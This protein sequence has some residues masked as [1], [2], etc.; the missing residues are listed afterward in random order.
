MKM[1][2]VYLLF[3]SLLMPFL[4]ISQ[5]GL[6]AHWSFDNT[7]G[8]TFFDL[9]GNG[10]HGTR[11]GA[12]VVEGKI[13]SALKFNGVGDYARIPADN[14][15]PPQ[16]LRDLGKGSISIWF[17][18]DNIPTNYGIAPMFYYGAEEMCNFFDAANQGM[19][20]E[21]GHSPIFP[22][23]EELFFTMWKNGC[24]YPSFCFDSN[25]PIPTG[26]WIHFVAVVGEDFNTGYLNG[27]EMTNRFYNFADAG[28]SQFFEDAVVHEKL[29]LGKGYWDE[30]VQHFDG[31][32]DDIRIYDRPLTSQE[33]EELYSDTAVVTSVNSI[34]GD[35]SSI[36]V[37]PN[38]AD[39]Y[40]Y[41]DL[42]AIKDNRFKTIEVINASGEAVK[43][44]DLSEAS[45]SIA[46]ADLP[47][48]FYMLNFLFEKGSIRKKV[49]IDR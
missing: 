13:G 7:E 27:Q 48:G 5:N 2:F 16:I 25:M 34:G 40:F 15:A 49:L 33:V 10:N 43:H 8:D 1:K 42:S 31:M 17:K 23:S 32:I 35:A 41:Y 45:G 4:S 6:V 36:I 29:W 39:E 28:A 46:V 24:T 12:E 26:Q 37:H 44:Q 11:Y 20:I 3:Y 18:A 22:G 30:T 19:I 47:K 14:E 9:S 38:P 21:L